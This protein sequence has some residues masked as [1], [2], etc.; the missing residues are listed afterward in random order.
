MRFWN[1]QVRREP[2]VVKE[3]L[4]RLLQERAPHPQNAPVLPSA[5]SRTWPLPPSDKPVPLRPIRAPPRG[6]CGPGNKEEDGALVHPSPR[7]SP[8]R[9]ERETRR[10]RSKD[11]MPRSC[12]KLPLG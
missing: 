6:E 4:W 11:Q 12:M 9:G 7:P 10:T 3:N 2:R 5:R 1:W 8:H